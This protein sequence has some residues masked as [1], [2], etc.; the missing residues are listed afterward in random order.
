MVSDW[1]M[2]A[3]ERSE[4]TNVLFSAGALVTATYW[5][6]S[7]APLRYPGLQIALSEGGIGWVPMLLDR[8]DFM[9]DHGG[10]AYQG[11]ESEI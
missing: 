9:L 6:F 5:L 7:G 3:G 8:L 4:M 10:R 11:W 1:V 2:P